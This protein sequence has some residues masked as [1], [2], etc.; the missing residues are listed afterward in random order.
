MAL[1]LDKPVSVIGQ[2]ALPPV[3]APVEL[4]GHADPRPGR[5]VA[6]WAS[7]T[8]PAATRSSCPQTMAMVRAAARMAETELAHLRLTATARPDVRRHAG[9]A[10]RL[11][12]LGR[13]EALLGIDDGTGRGST[14]RLSPRHSEI[15]LLLASAPQGLS[16]DEL[17]VL[18]YEDGQHRLHAARRAEPAAQPARR[19][20]CSP[21]VPTGSRRPRRRLAR[22]TRRSCRGRRGRRAARLPRAAAAAL[23]RA[24]RGPAARARSPPRCGRAV[25]RSGERRPDVDV[26]AVVVG[27]RRLRDV[28]GPAR[29]RRGPLA[30]AAAGP[31][32]R[33][34]GSTASSA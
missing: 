11:E 15:L 1:A 3:R 10:L 21:R 2:R 9:L 13:T 26:D 7:S 12:A 33:S 32:A 8:S 27:R 14:L 5:R 22:R 6:C 34:P 19:G 17:A 31:S 28:A 18:L 4:C 25:L 23:D 29:R 20:R 16:G 24:G 30:A